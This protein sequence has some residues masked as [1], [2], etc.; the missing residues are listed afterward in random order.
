[1]IRTFLCSLLVALVTLGWAQLRIIEAENERDEAR[2]DA[3]YAR[4]SE[5]KLLSGGRW[6]RDYNAI[7]GQTSYRFARKKEQR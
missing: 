1:M 7:T 5:Q 3:A 2:G 4:E 6:V